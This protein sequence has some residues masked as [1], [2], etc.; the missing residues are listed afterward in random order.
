MNDFED[1]ILITIAV[2]VSFFAANYF[3][4]RRY[5]KKITHLRDNFSEYLRALD[6]ENEQLWKKL[7]KKTPRKKTNTL[8][9][10]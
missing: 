2:V 5:N 8:E 7:N 4:G 6:K 1:I 10:K 3:H 9:F